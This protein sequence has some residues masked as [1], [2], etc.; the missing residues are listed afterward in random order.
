MSFG[1]C[2]V[3]SFEHTQFRQQSPAVVHVRLIFARPVKS[4]AGEHLQAGQVDLVPL[5]E[6]HISLG[7]VLA[8]D[9]HELNR[10]EKTGRDGGMAGRTAEQARVLCF[11]GLD[12]IQCGGTD[13]KYAH[14]VQ[15]FSDSASGEARGIPRRSQ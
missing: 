2:G 10:A 9:P 7:K 12:G 8:D 11:R 13:D 6:L 14:K 4:L 15:S 1:Q 3:E 5:V